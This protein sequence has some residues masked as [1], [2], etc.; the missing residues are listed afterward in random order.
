MNQTS[1]ISRLEARARA[2]GSG[3]L[4][5]VGLDPHPE[6]L[7]RKDAS[8]ALDACK[9]IVDQTHDLA[10]AFKPNSAFFEALGSMGFEALRALIA[11]IRTVDP[12]VPV[13]LDAKRGDI[14]STAEAYARAAFEYLDADAITLSPYLGIDS[15]S[16]FLKYPGRGGFVLC[17]TSNPS[18]AEF[19][20]LMSEGES[21]AEQV[22]RAVSRWDQQG[23]ALG[24][25]V[26]A[27]GPATAARIRAAAPDA[28]FL[29]PGVGTQGGDLESALEASL[30][31]DGL[32]VLVNASRALFKAPD[33][34]A[35]AL[36][37][38]DSIAAAAQTIKGRRAV[39]NPD[40]H[41]L[42]KALYDS[43]CV[44]FG[45]FTL[46]SG[47]E[48]PIYLDLRRLSSSPAAMR[49]VVQQLTGLVSRLSFDHLAPI[50]Y[51]ALPM[52]AILAFQMG[53]SLI[54]PRR[55]AKDYGT[56]TAVEGVFKE[57]DTALMIDD[58]ATTGGSK[59][60]AAEKLTAAGLRV[61]EI[62][63][64]IDREGGARESLES[65][66]Y[67]LHA[68][69]TLSALLPPL[70]KMGAISPSQRVEIEAFL[71]GG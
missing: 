34:R 32:G 13:I 45:K 3:S 67:R 46:K 1:F 10:L 54:Y 58:L 50:P 57:G 37:L 47:A 9:S 20:G 21:I 71:R 52:G 41:A 27:T 68:L 35:E 22:A 44:R 25:V 5:C 43:G 49:V 51:A 56:K 62:V 60:E 40:L 63:V 16:P 66:G 18:A 8:G 26:G 48:S 17:A 23:E 53:R 7:T 19:Q 36:K 64:V 61:R 4:L 11:H 14:A 15:I 59:F 2:L 33:P 29:L 24:L 38:R 69:T 31:P 12:S 28:W 30:R 55:E 39:H 42:A 70:E 6:L 65:A